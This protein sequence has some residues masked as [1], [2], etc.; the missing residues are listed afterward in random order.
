MSE[1]AKRKA[2]YKDLFEI[3]ENMTGEIIDG[4]L[5]ATPRPSRRHVHAATVLGVKVAP[6]YQF[7]EGGGPGD[8]IIYYE[9]EI[10][11][12][13][14]DIIVPDLAGWKKERLTTSPEEHRFAV[15]PDWI[16]EI[17]SPQTAQRDRIV[18]MRIFAR[19][20]VP[21]VWLIDP[22]LKTLEVFRL[23]S[24]KWSR[25]DAFSENDLVRAEPFHEIE[26][27]LSLFWLGED[28]VKS[29]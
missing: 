10:H 8:W 19:H 3:P 16:C 25:L 17:H 12:S 14:E 18:K 28:L 6:S 2:V 20:E 9:P 1:P 11:F 13:S 27:D 7:G 29:T 5:I 4:E 26:I 24:G 21:Y 15:C 23:D 22:A